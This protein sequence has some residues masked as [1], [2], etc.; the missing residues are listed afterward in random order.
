M[1]AEEQNSKQRHA[2]SF[3]YK[4]NRERSESVIEK[5]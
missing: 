2:Q 5:E 3:M 1:Q 4:R